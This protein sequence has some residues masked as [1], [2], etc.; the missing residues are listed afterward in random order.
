M[1]IIHKTVTIPES[2]TL[3]ITLPKNIMPGEVEIVMILDAKIQT[4][5]QNNTTTATSSAVSTS[6]T[7]KDAALSKLADLLNHDAKAMSSDK[8]DVEEETSN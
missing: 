4:E 7:L 5:V 3:S 6:E 8:K 1:E 2:H